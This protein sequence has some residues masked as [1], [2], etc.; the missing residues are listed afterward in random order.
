MP[1]DEM[2]ILDNSLRKL[3]DYSSNAM[4]LN[5]FITPLEKLYTKKAID[6]IN[7]IFKS[8]KYESL[9]H[10][11]EENM[12]IYEE[13]NEDGGRWFQSHLYWPDMY[14]RPFNKEKTNLN[15]I[16]YPIENTFDP[17]NR[18]FGLCVEGST[19]KG[20]TIHIFQNIN[21]YDIFGLFVIR[22]KL[23]RMPIF[24]HE[25]LHLLGFDHNLYRCYSAV[26][27]KVFSNSI[28]ET[29]WIDSD[30]I[31]VEM[32]YNKEMLENKPIEYTAEVVKEIR[33]PDKRP[34]KI[35]VKFP[36]DSDSK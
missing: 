20:I 14:A 9:I 25:F 23:G 2:N 32:M 15:V 18:Q 3:G 7:E 24:R 21:Y 33:R 12:E 31:L 5:G 27:P 8:V 16:F 30:M 36:I 22:T 29:Q 26:G 11:I 1:V 34:R 13:Y 4:S 10:I 35:R 6:E 17:I 28:G 19:D